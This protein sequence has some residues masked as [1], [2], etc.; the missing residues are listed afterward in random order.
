[1]KKT[2][3]ITNKLFLMLMI[4]GVL[5]LAN[6]PAQAASF[7]KARPKLDKYSAY[8]NN[9]VYLKWKKIKGAKRY[10]IQRIRKNN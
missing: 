6:T 9:R 5:L 1:M 7:T 4:F 8:A 3:T 2:F 10:E